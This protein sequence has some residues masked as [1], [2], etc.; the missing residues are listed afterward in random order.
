MNGR[1]MMKNIWT[2]VMH[3]TVLKVMLLSVFPV[4]LTVFEYLML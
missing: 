4:L 1:V 3:L 2:L